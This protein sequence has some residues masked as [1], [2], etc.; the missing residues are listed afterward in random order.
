MTDYGNVWLSS[1]GINALT[2]RDRWVLCQFHK[3]LSMNQC[4]MVNQ[5]MPQPCLKP[6]KL[7]WTTRI[8]NLQLRK[9]LLKSNTAT[10]E[11]CHINKV[12]FIKCGVPNTLTPLP[13]TQPLVCLKKKK[14][15]SR[16]LLDHCIMYNFFLFT[17]SDY[18]FV[19]SN[20]S[21]LRDENTRTVWRYQGGYQYL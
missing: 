19:F 16:C 4:M 21:T 5:R 7:P 6:I 15:V 17:A 11:R 2:I 8:S 12:T 20:C 3:D 18:P 14:L 9:A 13:P 1:N 10:I